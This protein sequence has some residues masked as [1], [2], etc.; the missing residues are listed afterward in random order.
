MQLISQNLP[1]QV[2]KKNYLIKI[3]NHAVQINKPLPQILGALD[4]VESG[5]TL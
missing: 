4:L 1:W 5:L 2:L 3:L